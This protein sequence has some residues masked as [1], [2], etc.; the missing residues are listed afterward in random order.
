MFK[1][2][3][4]VNS[5]ENEH[6]LKIANLYLV[7]L[8]SLFLEEDEMIPSISMFEMIPSISVFEISVL[9]RQIS[10]KC[11]SASSANSKQALRSFLG[12]SSYLFSPSA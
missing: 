3:L 12:S 10:H 11:L 6:I 4:I 9:A 1:F 7:P 5:L 8:N 2:I